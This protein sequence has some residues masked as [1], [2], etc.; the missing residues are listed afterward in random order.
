[1]YIEIVHLPRL[2]THHNLS[3]CNSTFSVFLSLTVI[4]LI[5]YVSGFF[6]SFTLH[7]LR[8]QFC[9]LDI[10]CMHVCYEQEIVSLSFRCVSCCMRVSKSYTIFWTNAVVGDMRPFWKKTLCEIRGN[11]CPYWSASHGCFVPSLSII[12]AL[13]PSGGFSSQD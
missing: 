7:D 9:A 11:G 5:K 10:V 4:S 1:M 2:N 13:L 3:L 12:T 6:F 8:C